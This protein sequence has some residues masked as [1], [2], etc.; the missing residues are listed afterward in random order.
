MV[1]RVVVGKLGDFVKV[2]EIEYLK[3][4]LIFLFIVLV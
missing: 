2:V 1:R 3:L 4:D